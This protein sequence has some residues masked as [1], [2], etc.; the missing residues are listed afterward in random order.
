[1]SNAASKV[2]MSSLR[3][4]KTER[5]AHRKSSW[6]FRSMSPSARVASVSRRG[7]ASRPASC[8][9][10][11]KAPNRGNRSTT[12]GTLRLL[13]EHR[14]LLADALQVLLVLERCAHRRVNQARVYTRRAERGEG[15]SPIERLRDPRHLVQLHAAQPLHQRGN[16]AR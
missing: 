10:R 14:D 5:S 9:N 15:A 11:A 2:G 6:C 3:L 4:T 13:D 7:P 16:F 8:S 1:M 12:S